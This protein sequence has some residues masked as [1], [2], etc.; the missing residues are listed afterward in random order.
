M[1][2][3]YQPTSKNTETCARV[4]RVKNIMD[5]HHKGIATAVIANIVDLTPRSVQRIIRVNL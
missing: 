4:V 1:A 3:I 2:P 5:L